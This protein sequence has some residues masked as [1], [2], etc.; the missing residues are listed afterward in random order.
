[1]PKIQFKT[2]LIAEQSF[3]LAVADEDECLEQAASGN[4]VDP[5]WGKV[6]DAAIPTAKIILRQK[7]EPGLKTLEV[8]CGVGLLGI[9]ALSAGMDVTLSDHEPLAVSQAIRN[10]ELNG[11]S[12]VRG[13]VMNWE[14][15]IDEKFDLLIA[16]DVLYEKGS[17]EALV[18]LTFKLL[19]PGGMFIIGDPGR[20][21]AKDFLGLAMD[22]DL[23]VE[24]FDEAN[25]PVAMP[26]RN[27]FQLMVIHPPSTNKKKRTV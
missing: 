15:P 27:Q 14:S 16:S 13:V 21:L 2:I 23:V 11:F 24:L 6:W 19:N 10:A 12:H 17:H 3:K 4:A 20:S 26:A 7:W 9:A 1:M 22:A 18:G 25:N 8:G 5:Y